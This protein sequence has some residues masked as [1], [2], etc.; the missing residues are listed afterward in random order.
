M[1]RNT[2]TDFCRRD[3]RRRCRRKPKRASPTDIAAR[4][5]R[6]RKSG[7]YPRDCRCRTGPKYRRLWCGDPGTSRLCH[8]SK[9]HYL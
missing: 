1:K 4:S 2:G 9:S 6:T 7:Q 5:G 3:D 8:R